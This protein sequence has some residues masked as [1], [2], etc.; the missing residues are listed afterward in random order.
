[1]RLMPPL[2]RPAGGG[3]GGGRAAVVVTTVLCLVAGVSAGCARRPDTSLHPD[4]PSVSYAP[5]RHPFAG[6]RL[7]HD[8]DTAAARWQAAYGGY[9]L[10]PITDRPQA[11]WLTSPQD[12]A[13]L[14]VLAANAR[15]QDA[16]PVLVAYYL[17]N[18]GCT[19]HKDGAPTERAYDHWIRRLLAALRPTR[20][21][22]VLEPDAVPADCF[23]AAR[24][25]LL[26]RTVKRLSAA[27]QYV[28]LDAG[29][30]RW[31]SPGDVADRLLRS[32]IAYAEGFSVN[33]SNRQTI[34][35]SYRWGRELSDLLGD[36]DFVIDTSRNGLGPPPHQ[37]DGKEWCNP[38]R[39]GLGHPPTTRTRHRGLAA[40]LWIKAPGESDG[41]C[42]GE[43]T[44][45]FSPT[46][47]R[48][49]ITKSPYVPA[50]YRRMAAAAPVP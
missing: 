19:H 23:D 35:D 36:R 10:S 45:E 26:A 39:Q 48:T 34:T 30:S 40:L 22:I 17:P 29:H 8:T 12:L 28:Y 4:P 50:S 38:R 41:R 20:A 31:K 5:L 42:G 47:A 43:T 16:L 27:G 14:P 3:P 6:A 2:R 15:Q 32:G 21:A 18:R 1:M 44:Y 37:S 33:V 11:R 13:D 46:Q 25:K 9:W 49:L 24:A 7:Y